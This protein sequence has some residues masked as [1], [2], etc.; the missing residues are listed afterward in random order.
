MSSEAPHD[1]TRYATLLEQMTA[2]LEMR[3]A[4][5]EADREKREG[6]RG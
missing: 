3:L 2:W 6:K 1:G 4:A 5:R